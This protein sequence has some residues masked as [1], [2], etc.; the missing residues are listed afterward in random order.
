LAWSLPGAVKYTWPRLPRFRSTLA[1]LEGQ[2]EQ[3]ITDE[4]RGPL[5][6]GLVAGRATATDVGVVVSATRPG[7][8]DGSGSA[9]TAAVPL[10]VT[11]TL[12]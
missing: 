10:L 7:V 6:V 11:A 2:R 8:C 5:V 3:G 1:R 9:A 4:D 12:E